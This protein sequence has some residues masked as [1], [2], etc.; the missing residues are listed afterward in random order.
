[1][2]HSSEGGWICVP[3]GPYDR[4]RK[5]HIKKY[6]PVN[7]GCTIRLHGIAGRMK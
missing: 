3:I 6:S 1:M 4:I 7:S 5:T 2:Q